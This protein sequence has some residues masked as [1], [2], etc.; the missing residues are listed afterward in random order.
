MQGEGY[1]S[2]SD[3]Y[4]NPGQGQRGEQSSDWDSL[5]DESEDGMG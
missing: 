5:Y 2:D 1:S 3:D 4:K